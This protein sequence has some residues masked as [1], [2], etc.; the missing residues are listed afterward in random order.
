M[1]AHRLSTVRYADNI[2]VMAEGRVV[3]SGTH[4]KLLAARS[5]YYE[6]VKA[7]NIDHEGEYTR[8]KLTSPSW[9]SSPY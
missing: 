2:V 1:I 4:D 8:I 9:R 7:Q 6:F 3:E 5:Y